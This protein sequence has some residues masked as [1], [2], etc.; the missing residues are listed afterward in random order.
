MASALDIV[1]CQQWIRGDVGH[2]CLGLQQL[3]DEAIVWDGVAE[4]HRQTIGCG[5]FR[6]MLCQLVRHS[7]G[8]LLLPATLALFRVDEVAF[9]EIP[10]ATVVVVALRAEPVQLVLSAG[11]FG[12]CGISVGLK[13]RA[14]HGSYSRPP[15]MQLINII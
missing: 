4:V 7:A 15:E 9:A 3:L 1:A 14:V 12:P 10:G 13:R 5:G 6:P 11:P 2:C 8:E